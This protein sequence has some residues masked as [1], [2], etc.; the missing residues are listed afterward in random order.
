MF[1]CIYGLLMAFNVKHVLDCYGTEIKLIKVQSM[2]PLDSKNC[3]TVTSGLSAFIRASS[4]LQENYLLMLHSPQR[5]HTN[6][7]PTPTGTTV[8]VPFQCDFIRVITW[9]YPNPLSQWIMMV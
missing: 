3:C 2:L 1:C 6:M 9:V 5:A 4:A 8:A 7:P